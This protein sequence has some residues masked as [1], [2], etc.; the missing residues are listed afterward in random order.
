MVEGGDGRSLDLLKIG[1]E[2]EQ[3]CLFY[4]AMSR[5]RDRLFAYAPIKKSNGTKWGLSSYLGRLASAITQ[6]QATVSRPLPEAPE[7]ANINLVVDGGLSFHGEQMRLYGKC[8]RRFFYTYVL[9]IGGR[10]TSTA[11][12]HMHEA[13]RTVYKAVIEGTAS[14]ND[15]TQLNER[16]EAAFADHGLADH[17]YV[18]EYRAFALPM[19]RFFAAIREGHTAEKPTALS[20]V[21]DNER[22]IVMPDDVLI[23]ADGKRTFRRVK[24]GHHSASHADDV[25]SAALIMAA[26]QAFPDATVELVYLSDQKSEALNMTSKK[27]DNRKEVLGSFL[28]S[29]RLGQFPANPSSRIC[30]G[31]P[32]FYVCGSTPKGTLEKKF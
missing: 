6:S 26:K 22:I 17:G 8:P 5:A 10:R 29:I 2:E 4:V 20:L 21:F 7:E 19:L 11:F 9:Q 15:P 14:I 1:H 18:K 31:C 32:A 25:D 30:P 28:K 16:V 3:E 13:V 23:R 12:M 24:T 27:L